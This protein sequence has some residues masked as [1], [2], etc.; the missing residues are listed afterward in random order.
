MHTV[1]RIV[2]GKGRSISQ[3]NKKGCDWECILSVELLMGRD[4]Q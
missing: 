1:G 3:G 4:G 2:N